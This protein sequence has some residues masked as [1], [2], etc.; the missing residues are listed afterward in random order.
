[1]TRAIRRDL[2]TR[3][4]HERD[5]YPHVRAF[6][7]AESARLLADGVVYMPEA[8]AV[9]L[10]RRRGQPVPIFKWERLVQ[11]LMTKSARTRSF[12]YDAGEIAT[13]MGWR[14]AS[15]V[16]LEMQRL[17]GH[18]YVIDTRRAPWGDQDVRGWQVEYRLRWTAEQYACVMRQQQEGMR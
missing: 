8:I 18:G 13:R 9:M 5:R 16:S 4:E 12:W 10:C 2:V 14:H 15:R 6:A 17:R 1:M 11:L 3:F 7:V